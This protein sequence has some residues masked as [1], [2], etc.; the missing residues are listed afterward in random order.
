MMSQ[1]AKGG[2]WV[3]GWVCVGQDRK[4]QIPPAAYKEY[5]FQAK[6]AIVFTNGSQRSGGFAIGIRDRVFLT[7]ILS[8]IIEEGAI[9][10]QM[11][12][13]LPA[14]V[15]AQPGERLLAVRGSGLA[16]SFLQKGPIVEEAQRHPELEVFEP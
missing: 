1:L 8:R 7:P 9:G 6:Q 4:I 2:K 11:Q 14:A 3:F 16:L 12:I 5:G 13:V 10:D 15:C